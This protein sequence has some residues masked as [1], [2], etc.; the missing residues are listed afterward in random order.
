MK[1]APLLFLAGAIMMIHT[2]WG[3]A[4]LST[5]QKRSAALQILQTVETGGL[6]ALSVVNPA[7]YIEHDLRFE[8]GVPAL[9]KRV[10]RVPAGLKVNTVRA[11]GLLP[12]KLVEGEGNKDTRMVSQA[13]VG[14]QPF[15]DVTGMILRTCAPEPAVEILELRAILEAE[16]HVD[17]S[18]S[19]QWNKVSIGRKDQPVGSGLVE[20]SNPD[21]WGKGSA[22]AGL[23]AGVHPWVM[24]PAS[25]PSASRWQPGRAKK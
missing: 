17:C 11:L 3:A 23:P 8:S 5:Q 2:S 21:T 4:A 15:K 20:S 14:H 1:L 25:V 10:S 12:S 9:R 7:K 24:G 19:V 6:R 22:E 18:R 13:D 16:G